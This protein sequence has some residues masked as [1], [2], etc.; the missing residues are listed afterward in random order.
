MEGD[1]G[2][3]DHLPII[4]EIGQKTDQ[5]DYTYL[6][7]ELGKIDPKNIKDKTEID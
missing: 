5:T 2:N 1:R 3:S 7:K 4:I 6:K